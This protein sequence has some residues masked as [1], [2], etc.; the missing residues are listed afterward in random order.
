MLKYART[1]EEVY[2]IYCLFRNLRMIQLLGGQDFDF[3]NVSFV[4][5]ANLGSKNIFT[6]C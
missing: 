6:C 1:E 5:H 2:V 4:L 3:T